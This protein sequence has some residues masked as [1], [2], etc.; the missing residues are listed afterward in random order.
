MYDTK[1]L[2]NKPRYYNIPKKSSKS[3]HYLH[4]QLYQEISGVGCHGLS[5]WI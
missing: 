5:R 4:T 3:H 1:V 2:Q